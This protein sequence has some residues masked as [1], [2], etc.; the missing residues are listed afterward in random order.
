LVSGSAE[1]VAPAA[2][3]ERQARAEKEDAGEGFWFA[4]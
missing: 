2:G 1:P 3:A 4:L